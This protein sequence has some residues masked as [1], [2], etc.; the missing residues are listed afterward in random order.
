MDFLA[1]QW[2]TTEFNLS[3]LD[4]HLWRVDLRALRAERSQATT[5][6][7]EDERIRANRLLL[8][9]DQERFILGRGY[10]R[11]LLGRY[12]GT[13]AEAIRFDYSPQGKPHLHTPQSDLQFNVS[14]CGDTIL[15]AFTRAG[16]IGIDSE[17]KRTLN[18]IH[19]LVQLV[20]SPQEQREFALLDLTAQTEFF[21]RQWVAKEAFLKATGE[22]IASGSMSSEIMSRTGRWAGWQLLWID[23]Y[24]GWIAALVIEGEIGT[25]YCREAFQNLA[26]GVQVTRI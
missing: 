8:E 26:C 1:C 2:E 3:G 20:C 14:H 16:R 6:L 24:P 10:L 17:E 5:L 19:A 21:W 9:I 23:T 25:L 18:D 13:K 7:S 12:L 11:V 15:Y 4:V 22:G